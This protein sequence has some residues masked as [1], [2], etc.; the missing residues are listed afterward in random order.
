MRGNFQEF[1]KITKVIS[2]E[3]STVGGKYSKT[4]KII[5]KVRACELHGH[6]KL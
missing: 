1:S 2:E 5:F 3:L 6:K 4:C